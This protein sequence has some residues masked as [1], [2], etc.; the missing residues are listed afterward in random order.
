MAAHGTEI[1]KNL[2]GYCGKVVAIACW[3]GVLQPHVAAAIGAE[4]RAEIEVLLKEMGTLAN[5][6]RIVDVLIPMIIGEFRKENPK[7]PE[8]MWNEF[9]LIA[10]DEIKKTMPELMEPIITIYDTNFTTE[11][12]KQLVAFYTSPVGH[13][14]VTQMHEIVPQTVAMAQAW[15]ERAGA[16]VEERIRA[17]AKQKGYNL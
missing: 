1:M 4:K 15:G 5:M 14:I 13:K 3:M 17:V 7:I 8:A 12:I 10:E 11:E 9:I 2:L 16:R 6:N